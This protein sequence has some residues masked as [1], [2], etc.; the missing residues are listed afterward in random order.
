MP[1]AV[2]TFGVHT[3][4]VQGFTAMLSDPQCHSCCNP[5]PSINLDVIWRIRSLHTRPSSQ[6]RTQPAPPSQRRSERLQI[7]LAVITLILVAAE[8]ITRSTI[9]RGS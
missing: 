3:P 6:W 8:W 7:A 5:R 9:H 4:A 1:S 2:A